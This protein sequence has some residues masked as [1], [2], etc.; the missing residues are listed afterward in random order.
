MPAAATAPMLPMRAGTRERCRVAACAGNESRGSCCWRFSA[1]SSCS[2]AAAA[3]NGPKDN[4]VAKMSPSDAL[5]QVKEAVAAAT[6]VHIVGTGTTG[7]QPL[8]LNLKLVKGKGGAG[9]IAVSGLSFDIIRIG[10][11]AYFKGS[12]KASGASSRGSAAAQL[13]NGKWLDGAGEQGRARPR[14]RRSRTSTR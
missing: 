5:A 14:S 6:S 10:D 2:P 7:G 13:F 1:L 4:G 9:H 11:K 12:S 3:K 8:A